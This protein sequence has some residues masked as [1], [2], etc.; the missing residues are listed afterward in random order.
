MR[1]ITR[2]CLISDFYQRIRGAGETTKWEVVKV[3]VLLVS[4]KISWAMTN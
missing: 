3:K 1:H 4:S 2:N